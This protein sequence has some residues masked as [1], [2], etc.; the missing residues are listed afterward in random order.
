MYDK[1]RD[2]INS[3]GNSSRKPWR[4]WSVS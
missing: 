1:V 3:D 4:T 2:N